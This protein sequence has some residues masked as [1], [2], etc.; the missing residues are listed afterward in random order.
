MMRREQA[1][2][3]RVYTFCPLDFKGQLY[4]LLKEIKS[5]KE[6]ISASVSPTGII[7]ILL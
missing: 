7:V 5:F 4:V 1:S 2:H 3:T 6:H